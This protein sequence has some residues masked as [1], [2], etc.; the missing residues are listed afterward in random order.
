MLNVESKTIYL[1]VGLADTNGPVQLQ[2]CRTFARDKPLCCEMTYA[3][4]VGWLLD[5]CDRAMVLRGS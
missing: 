3:Q 2:R 4:L 1:V 5:P